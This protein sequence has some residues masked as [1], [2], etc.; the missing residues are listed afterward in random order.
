MCSETPSTIGPFCVF[1]AEDGIRDRNVTGVQTCALPI[2]PYRQEDLPANPN[3]A[4][5]AGGTRQCNIRSSSDP[6]HNP[7]FAHTK[8]N[9]VSDQFDQAF[10][11][12]RYGSQAA[13]WS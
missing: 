8:E 5:V 11:D 4:T 12:E 6:L 7:P 9:T 13:L 3:E 10:W 2:L 1:Q